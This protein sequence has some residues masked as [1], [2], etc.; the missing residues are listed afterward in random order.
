MTNIAW[1]CLT[2]VWMG[3]DG[4]SELWLVQISLSESRVGV[5]G[6][7]RGEYSE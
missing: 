4:E 5:G 7:K 6:W 3:V 1:D 2:G